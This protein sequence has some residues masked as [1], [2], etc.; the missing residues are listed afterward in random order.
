MRDGAELQRAAEIAALD[1]QHPHA[2]QRQLAEH[3]DAVD[4]AADDDG[5]HLRVRLQL[6]EHV[7]ARSGHRLSV[8]G[9][10]AGLSPF[11]CRAR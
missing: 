2:L 11:R 10:N 9:A 8:A 1:Q 6:G 3:A 5:L 4:A 7:F